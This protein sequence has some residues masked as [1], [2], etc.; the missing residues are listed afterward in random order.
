MTYNYGTH[1][2]LHMCSFLAEA[3]DDEIVSHPEV[4]NRKDWSELA[5]KARDAL[6]ELYQEIGK[7][8]W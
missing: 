1:E 3:I 7:E 5:A 4:L 8:H 2:V 6:Y